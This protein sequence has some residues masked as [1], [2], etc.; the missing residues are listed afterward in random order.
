MNAGTPTWLGR[1]F[2]LLVRYWA[3]NMTLVQ[4][5]GG[6][7]PGF[8]YSPGEQSA[9]RAIASRVP[10]FEFAVWMTCVVVFALLC[11]GGLTLL[12]TWLLA[13]IH[14]GHS[15]E[16]VS[17]TAFGLSLGVDMVASLAVGFPVA[18]LAGSLLT[19]RLFGVSETDLPDAAVRAHYVQKLSFQFLRMALLGSGVVVAMCLW[20]PDRVWLLTRCIVPVLGPAVSLASVVYYG[21]RIRNSTQA[22]AGVVSEADSP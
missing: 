18:M 14:G 19:G 6:A 12:G 3:C 20:L 13:S 9:L 1:A 7:W 16:S 15:L 2:G 5:Q 17:A 8:G 21:V 22:A 10:S 11:F 4:N